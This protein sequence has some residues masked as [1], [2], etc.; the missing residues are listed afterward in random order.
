ML[1][2]TLSKEADKSIRVRTIDSANHIGSRMFLDRNSVICFKSALLMV[3]DRNRKRRDR[4]LR[5]YTRMAAC[6][7]HGL[8]RKD[9]AGRLSYHNLATNFRSWLQVMR[10]GIECPNNQGQIDPCWCAVFTHSE[11]SLNLKKLF[12]TLN[13]SL[14]W[15]VRDTQPSASVP[16]FLCQP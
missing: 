13:H 3:L 5:A 8:L 7:T 15:T 6:W 16:T 2:L 12:S 14:S 11:S 4:R 9:F 10:P 1:R